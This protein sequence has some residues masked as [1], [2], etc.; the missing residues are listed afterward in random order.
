MEATA[1]STA[2]TT[3]TD[4]IGSV[5]TII[6]GNATLMAFFV[7]GLVGVGIGLVKR[8]VGSY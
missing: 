2:I 1:M 4:M 3:V 7:A 6:E 5:I 8:L